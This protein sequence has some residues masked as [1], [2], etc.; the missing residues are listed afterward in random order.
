VAIHKFTIKNN[1]VSE[2]PVEDKPK[3]KLV[4]KKVADKTPKV[5][6]PG[7]KQNV[8]RRI[9]E[10]FVGAWREVRQV[11][12]PNRRQTWE[13]TFAVILFSLL[14]GATIFGLDALFTWLFTKVI[15]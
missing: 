15:L 12:W 6:K 8:F 3:K 1:K 11:R 13:L 7:K 14:L 9:G 2:E 10:Y 4:A 5:A